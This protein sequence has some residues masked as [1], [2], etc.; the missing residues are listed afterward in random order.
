[1]GTIVAA[2]ALTAIVPPAPPAGAQQAAA[3]VTDEPE[4]RAEQVQAPASTATARLVVAELTTALGPGSKRLPGEDLEPAGMPEP[5]EDLELRVL[6][7]NK[8][9]D[10]LDPLRLVV[11]VHPAVGSRDELRRAFD[12][13]VETTPLHVHDLPVREGRGLAAGEIAGVRDRFLGDELAWSE[14]GGVHPVRIAALR[15]TE[16]LDEV[17]T[18]VVYLAEPPSAP[19]LTVFVW[20]VDDLPW[21]V[22]SGHYPA[23][24]ERA[25]RIGGRLD[26]LLRSLER[27]PEAPVVMAVAPHLLEDLHDR[28]DGYTTLVRLPDGSLETHEVEPEHADARASNLALQRLRALAA[29]LPHAPIVS[30][31]ADADLGGLLR[32]GE[33]LDRLAA[34]LAVTGRNRVRVLLDRGPAANAHL[35]AGPIDARSLDLIPSELVLLPDDAVRAPHPNDALREPLRPLRSAAGRLMAGLVAD[36]HLGEALAAPPGRAGPVVDAQ[37]VLA[38]TA[39]LYHTT[40]RREGRTLLLLPPPMWSPEPAFAAELLTQT[41]EASWLE[42]TSPGDLASRGRKGANAL[43]LAEERVTALDDTLAD[44]LATAVRALEAAESA[45]PDE[46]STVGGHDPGTLRNNLLRAASRH[47]TGPALSEAL[48]LVGEVQQ[49][50]DEAFGEVVVASSSRVTLTSHH[51]QIP[52]TLQRS[53]GGPIAVQI[54]VASQGRLRW[55]EGHRSEVIVLGEGETQT[56]SFTTHAVSTGT[57]PVTV[58]VTDPSGTQELDRTT[59]SV[60]ST[61]VSTVALSVIGGAVLVLLAIGFLR[62][63]GGRPPP[64]RIVGDGPDAATEH[65][66]LR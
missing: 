53:R 35:V 47:Y 13:D 40:P 33:P 55:P 39:M 2:L 1:M 25:T 34:E 43:E 15:G 37:R 36:P 29:S 60:R 30:S 20:P 5:I 14:Q 17:V 18:A 9:S 56:V 16:V 23:Q 64:L 44:R 38:E 45:L 22:T 31:Y 28:A 12:G 4:E 51:G 62:R 21:R 6:V 3:V 59:L 42:L 27:H 11:E 57:F 8:G 46:P 10:H 48:A 63:R 24:V 32:A 61:A 58:R 65:A 50:T 7:E 26:V 66:A 52:I 19:L 54:E 41:L 49:A